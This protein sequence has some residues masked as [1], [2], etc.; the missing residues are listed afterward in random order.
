MANLIGTISSYYDFN[1]HGVLSL[2][3]GTLCFLAGLTV[4]LRDP[5]SKVNRSLFAFTSTAALWTLCWGMISLSRREET[6]LLWLSIGYLT[7]VP[8]ISPSLY[9][10]SVRWLGQ[11]N[12]K[13]NV[14]WGYL[15]AMLAA[16]PN[17]FFVE[18]ICGVKEYSW[19][20]Y[21]YVKPEFLPTLYMVYV[22]AVLFFYG[23]LAFANFYRA[24]RREASPRR[25]AQVR[26][27]LIGSLIAYTGAWD[28]L[29]AYRVPVYPFGYLSLL[30]FVGVL[31]YTIVRHQFLDI[32]IVLKRM[33]LIVGIYAVLLLFSFP[34]GVSLLKRF[35][36]QLSVE[37]VTAMLLFGAFF[38]AALSLGPFIYA[39]LVRRSFWLKGQLSMGLTHELKSPL[40]SIQSAVEM[41]ASELENP[42]LDRRKALDYM[43]MVQRNAVRL[44]LFVKDLLNIAKIQ[45]ENV[46]IEKAAVDLGD[47]IRSIGGGFRPLY[48]QKGIEVVYELDRVGRVEADPD[49]LQQVVSNLLSN[50]IKFSR[51]GTIRIAL[52][53]K[54]G[55]VTCVV[56]DQGCGVPAP[57][58]ERIFER[59][60]QGKN[61]QKGAG[62]GL[63]IA[64][65][66]VEAH[67]GRI[68]AESEGEGRGTKVTFT[69][70][71]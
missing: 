43:S 11:R 45:D 71:L 29:P 55:E 41:A 56:T 16:I 20:R 10:F 15:L 49:K 57:D 67:G 6:G 64:K 68:W 51:K 59:F 39:A 9:L 69:L 62:L 2:V 21:P 50:A 58:L 47:L 40:S 3:A 8:F 1:L 70:P 33:S 5:K 25:K 52:S 61:S 19:G 30:T 13:W 24:W 22:I 37:A 7:S 35:G 4:F 48:S 54:N 32:R 12:K 42:K 60:F 14:V 44:E 38:G 46:T 66:W 65:A 26:T 34:V 18:Y 27:I 28:F 17:G 63:A 36:S 53:R 23:F 31:V